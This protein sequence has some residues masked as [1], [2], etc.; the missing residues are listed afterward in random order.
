M[1]I[2]PEIVNLILDYSNLGLI[3]IYD[4]KMNK[5]RFRYNIKHERFAEINR[6]YD[7]VAIQ[8]EISDSGYR[9]NIYYSIPLRKVPSLT[10]IMTNVHS[11]NNY[12]S[13]V[14]FTEED[15]V[16]VEHHTSVVIQTTN[17]ALMIN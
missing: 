16:V 17:S 14:V 5:Y 8:T 4:K 2:P 13:I 3:F 6:L 11:I 1:W 9:T 12:M 10:S 15:D 7:S